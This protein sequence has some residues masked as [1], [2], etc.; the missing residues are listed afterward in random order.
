L[1]ELPVLRLFLLIA[2]EPYQIQGLI[3]F[4]PVRPLRKEGRFGRYLARKDGAVEK[5][6]N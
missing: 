1:H 6:D 5:I 2:A 4:K 3:G